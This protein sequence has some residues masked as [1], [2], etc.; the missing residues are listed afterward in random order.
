[1]RKKLPWFEIALA[2]VFLSATLYAAFSDAYNLP[3]RWFI[4]DDAYYYYKVAQNISEGRG[5]TFDG[6]HP[7]NGYHPLWLVI[8]IPIFALARFDIILPLRILAIVTGLLQL[9]SAI[10]LYRLI[11]HTLSEPAAV[12]AACFWAFHTYILVFL[13]KT[14]VESCITIFLV[15]VLLHALY[16]LELTWRNRQPSLGQIAGI[17]VLA[18]LVT[19]GR[20]DLIFF[21]LIVGIWVVFRASPLRYLLPL[22]MLA[23]IVST[24][25]A[26]LARLGF[27]A[28][29]DVSDTVLIMLGTALVCKI[30]VF[31]FA[32]LYEAPSSWRAGHILSRLLLGTAAGSLLLAVIL[33]AGSTVGNLPPLSRAVLLLDAVFTFALALLIRLVA[34]AFRIQSAAV[35]RYSPLSELKTHWKNWTKEGAAF[36]GVVGGT[37]SAFMLWNRLLFGTFTPVSGQIKHWWGMFTHSIYG[38]SASSW[39][40]FFAANPFSDFNAWAPPTA[41]ISTFSNRLLYV[42]GTGFGNPR[43]QMNF[44]ILLLGCALVVL[45]IPVFRK[46]SSVR[47]VVQTGMIPLFVGSWLQILSYNVTGYASPKEWYWLLEPVLLVLVGAMLVMVLSDLVIRRW[48][49]ARAALWVIVSWYGLH[50]AYA[51]WR[52]AY[53]LN[54]YGLHTANTPY[55]PVI[56]FLEANTEPGALIGMTGGGNVGYLMP[57]RTIVNMDGL[58]SSYEYFQALKAGTGADYLYDT[59]MRYVFANPT[60]LAANPYRGQFSD[61]L[62]LLVD[63]GGKDLMRLLPKVMD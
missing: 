9:G 11:K 1:M 21:S 30:P 10:L 15:L 42:E 54:P 31:Y 56:S 18:I 40:T 27:A 45:A 47:A 46:R 5:S 44:L 25:A 8:C 37:L 13:Y 29:Y 63:W 48:A 3:N 34:Y 38:T 62:E 50:G 7:T 52:D 35:S 49:F 61:R 60:L 26:F 58:I 51:Y 20:L 22:D 16:R 43:W 28:Y 4:R 12:L 53:A 24:V 6:I 33:L 23:I 55:T 41:S 2:V 39:L 17:G 57:S 14:G 59:G 32:G 19:F 36:F